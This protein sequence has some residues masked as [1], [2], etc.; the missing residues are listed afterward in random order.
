[1]PAGL[2]K[3]HGEAREDTGVERLMPGTLGFGEGLGEGSGLLGGPQG[4]GR[5]PIVV[6]AVAESAQGS[7]EHR[8]VVIELPRGGHAP[9]GDLQGLGVEHVAHS[10]RPAAAQV[11]DDLGLVVERGLPLQ[12]V[13][14]GHLVEEV[15]EFGDRLLE[16][17]RDG[18][19]VPPVTGDQRRIGLAR[20]APGARTPARCHRAAHGRTTPHAR[21]G[22]PFPQLPGLA[23]RYC[24]T[25]GALPQAPRWATHR[26]WRGVGAPPYSRGGVRRR[27][28]CP[29]PRGACRR[30]AS[31]GGSRPRS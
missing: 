20:G 5:A 25:T 17:L 8:D 4:L 22:S 29:A 31:A 26:E 27:T 7:S 28:V 3:P 9:P 19:E 10:G 11:G 16:A 24:G 14:G 1:M 13:G 15:R 23:Q 2:R 21:R 6:E 18:R 30:A 12:P